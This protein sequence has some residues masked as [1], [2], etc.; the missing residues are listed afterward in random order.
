MTEKISR[1]GR[2]AISDE[3]RIDDLEKV[4]TF[5]ITYN[6]KKI[7]G[8]LD[9]FK[10]TYDAIC[11]GKA[12]SDKQVKFCKEFGLARDSRLG[13]CG[14]DLKIDE[15]TAA[16]AP[17]GIR[18][19]K[20]FTKHYK[21]GKNFVVNSYWY[22]DFSKLEELLKNPAVVDTKSEFYTKRQHKLIDKYV[23]EYCKKKEEKEMK[24]EIK[25]AGLDP[26]YVAKL[27]A[28]KIRAAKK[29]ARTVARRL[30]APAPAP[31]EKPA[32]FK[33]PEIYA[34]ERAANP[35]D[36]PPDGDPRAWLSGAEYVEWT[37]GNLDADDMINAWRAR[38][39]PDDS[40]ADAYFERLESE[41]V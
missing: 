30:Q 32:V 25:A 14:L 35:V 40:A 37:L 11:K 15:I 28:K 22:I 23:F 31:A 24:I 19:Q 21:S 6:V 41:F 38:S 16:L 34:D 10:K 27:E 20:H 4:L 39:E 1:R 8:T 2:P 33:V 29:R 18:L 13:I 9:N 17:R 3:Q 36:F 5:K 7:Y 26:E 12:G